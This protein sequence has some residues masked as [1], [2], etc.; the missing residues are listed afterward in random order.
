M[1]TMRLLRIGQP[2][3][4]SEVSMNTT[5]L[6]NDTRSGTIEPTIVTFVV[7]DPEVL[8]ALSEYPDGP[9]RTNFLVTSLKVGVL[10]LKAARGTL[11]SDT[12]RREGD[13]VMEELGTRLNTWRSKFEERVTGSL[14]HYFDPQQGTFTERVHR[15]TKADGELATVVRQQVSDAQT[16][17]SKVFEQFIG[18]NSQLFRMLDPA[19]DNQLVA[20]LRRSLD[21]VVQ[22]QNEAILGQ[23]SL[24]NKN[25][26]LVRFLAEL[27]AKHGDLN[28]A[29]SRDMQAIV[30]EF[31]LDKEDSALSRLVSRV[32]SAQ[33]SLTA[34]LSLDNQDSALQRLHRMLQ[35]NQHAMLRQQMELASR[36]D[37]A[38][39]TMNAR[40]EESA[41][42]TRHGMEFES[43][44]G[45]HL[46]RL[47]QSSGDIV[48]D[49]GAT[50]GLKPNCKIGDHVITIGPEKLAA[51]ARIV[52]EAKES[53]SYDLTKTLEE[54]DTARVNRQ[55]DVCVF[56]HSSRTAP[57]SIPNF[58]RFGRDIVVKWNADDDANDVWLEAALMVAAA[59]SV[60]AASHDKQDAASFEKIDKAVE[61]IRK[62][63][64]GFEEIN[65]SANTAKSAVEKILNRARLMQE[66][67]SSQ[68]QAIVDEI[69]KLKDAA[70]KD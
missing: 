4:V 64:E 39:E 9:A 56:V 41:K 23:F 69:L 12:L 13:R 35:D 1:L 30:A 57:P 46:R 59:L 60:K 53:A 14:E 65:T 26:A 18:E 7:S 11:D 54:A 19:G 29:L 31:S 33:K 21:A 61:R 68:V 17:L 62:S 28:N 22:T 40:R 38:I 52:I 50:T 20:A 70:A 49:T 63:L 6:A 48:Q 3:L 10:A 24:D 37:T 27:T 51:G 42:S 16:T 15:L 43:T 58:Q 47:V 8:L 36:L 66:G 2:I 25:G 55:A 34:E 45:D 32:E 5:D 44:L 67:L